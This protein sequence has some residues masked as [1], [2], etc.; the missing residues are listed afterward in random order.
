MELRD[1]NKLIDLTDVELTPKQAI[2]FKC[3][4]CCCFQAKEVKKCE[5]K[6]CALYKFKNKWFRTPSKK[7][8]ITNEEL[9]RRRHM[10]EY[11][12]K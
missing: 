12:E 5:A 3:Y 6:D 11:E 10:F 2:L 9:E 4:E 1:Y 8:N 7:Y